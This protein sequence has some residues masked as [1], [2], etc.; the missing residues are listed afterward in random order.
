[1][2]LEK[3]GNAGVAICFSNQALWLAGGEKCACSLSSACL[4]STKAQ[5]SE[6]CFCVCP[7]ANSMTI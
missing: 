7:L 2:D 4:K 1:M 3:C 6:M 5:K